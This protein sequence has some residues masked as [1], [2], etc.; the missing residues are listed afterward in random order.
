MKNS[1]LLLALSLASFGALDAA[2]PKTDVVIE[3]VDSV[4]L[5]VEYVTENDKASVVDV[6]AA[7]FPAALCEAKELP[8][9]L[10]KGKFT[11]AV[12]LSTGDCSYI[13]K[14]FVTRSLTLAPTDIKKRYDTALLTLTK[15]GEKKQLPFY[16]K[17]GKDVRGFDFTAPPIEV[18]GEAPILGVRK[19]AKD[20]TM[21]T[22]QTVDI[23]GDRKTLFPDLNPWHKWNT[24]DPRI[25]L[26]YTPLLPTGDISIL[27]F[28]VVGFTVENSIAVPELK[29]L[30]LKKYSLRLRGG[31]N[32][33]FHS[34]T[35]DLFQNGEAV[36]TGSITLIPVLAQ[37][38]LFYDLRPKGW[39]M[40]ISPFFRLADGIIFS[41]VS[42][43]VKPAYTSLLAAGAESSRSGSYIG[44]GF[45]AALGV[46]VRPDKWPV[47]FS[48]DGGYL[49]H[50]QDISGQ[51]F[52][53]NVGA[54]WH[55]A[56]KPP[57]PKMIPIQYLGNKSVMLSLK[58]TVRTPD[59]K[60]L[61]GAT[62]KLKAKGST[63]VVKQVD[64]N[65]KG[66]YAMEIEPGLDYT[67]DAHKD[68]YANANVELPLMSNDKKTKDQDFI[69]AELTYSLEGVN[70]KPDS[71]QLIKG[72]D[73]AILELI[74]FLQA[75]PEIRIE[76]G[77]HTAAAGTDDD[78]SRALS[79]KRAEAVR[80]F[81][82]AKGI[83]GD[84]LT[85]VGYG[86]S[87]PIADGK[88]DAGAKLNRRVEVR[89]LVE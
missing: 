76:I 49:N 12:K 19:F 15:S 17:T 63:A 27:K 20:E 9:Y 1:A 7:I 84:R 25:S 6:K 21:D 10:P 48:V 4:L 72:A 43:A 79:K 88:T 37:L 51:Y 83:N 53:F 58:G 11:G 41:S 8:K 38:T 71:D 89:I 29:F 3:T 2:P 64:S 61:T 77:G 23:G 45:A 78:S 47:A 28:G 82:I 44:H 26:Y 35:Q 55:Y 39:G 62:I 16:E 22:M 75:N 87:K 31:I 80:K 59:G 85:S 57:E 40:T 70:F 36:S 74:K 67:L 73:K 81:I 86:G 14:P 50:S 60:T 42:T 68:G 30:P 32:A 46:E 56:V 34:F 52:M 66:Q 65:D 13:G 54:S 33:G 69:L 5:H 18:A 24:L